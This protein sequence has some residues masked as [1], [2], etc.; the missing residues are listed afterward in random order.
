MPTVTAAERDSLERE[1]LTQMVRDLTGFTASPR[2]VLQRLAVA[3]QRIAL[4]GATCVLEL[5]GEMIHVAA[6]SGITSD[7]RDLKFAMMPAPSLFRD[8]IG[9]RRPVFT[10]DGEHDARVDPRFREPLNIRHAAVAPIIIDDAV[11]GL[12]C[13]L[14]SGRGGFTVEDMASLQRL[15]DHTALALHSARLVRTAEESAQNAHSHAATVAR[16]GVQLRVLARTAQ[17]LANA[18]TRE[19]L[20]GGLT[21][22]IEEELSV[23]V[24]VSTTPTPFDARPALNSRAA[25]AKCIRM[26][27][28]DISGLR[29]WET[30]SIPECHCLS[31]TFR[32]IPTSPK[33]T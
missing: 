7:F 3:A 24:A 22:I 4:C 29:A 10:N 33:C 26:S 28:R 19:E 8:A 25:S 21:R 5:H 17:V 16:E 11:T 13:C 12:L 15:A 30:W 32:G 31:V 14:N 23:L 2:A 18:V 27:S 1:I 9:K 6:T 20:Y